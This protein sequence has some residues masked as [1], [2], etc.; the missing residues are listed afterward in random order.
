MKIES[1]IFTQICSFL[2]YKKFLKCVKEYNGDNKVH[3][4]TCYHHLLVMIF[5]QL[6][7]RTSLT[8]IEQ[9]LM[10]QA[11]KLYHM[12]FGKCKAI[13]RN[14]I[15]KANE[16]RNYKIYEDYAKTLIEECKNLYKDDKNNIF[17]NELNFDKN[18]NIYALDS[19]IIRVAFSLMPWANYMD[20]ANGAVKLHTLLD[21]NGNIPTVN[22]ITKGNIYDANIIN[23]LL[24]KN[25]LNYGDLII[26]DRG[27][28]KY[29]KLF[30]LEQNKLFYICRAI[31]YNL[32]FKRLSSNKVEKITEKEMIKN[33][34]DRRIIFDQ[35]IK[36]TTKQAKKDYPNNLRLIKYKS[37]LLLKYNEQKTDKKLNKE[38]KDG[39]MIF[40]TNNFKIKAEDIIR[41]Y[42][43]RWNIE[44]FFKW[45][46][47]NLKIKHFYSN[48]ENG[49]KIQIWTAIITYLL[50]CI[51]RKKLSL[52]AYSI[53]EILQILSINVFERTHI[54]QLFKNLEYKNLEESY[55]FEDDLLSLLG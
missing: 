52:E 7:S 28:M 43:E 27:Y 15:A 38:D 33:N 53:H 29:N 31:K 25:Q 41:L 21:L 8:D 35:I 19:S 30:L 45:I 50:I 2:D 23:E 42:K 51:L 11:N 36:F 22:I 47:Q 3:H 46:K 55:E 18:N 9:S 32:K 16:A 48:K 34:L 49:V 17:L 6:T 37:N 54:N 4:Y 13:A 10:S 5:A 39:I 1:T 40:I 12:G 20:E 44:I 26:M 14:T 24:D